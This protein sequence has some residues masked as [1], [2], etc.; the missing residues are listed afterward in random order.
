MNTE[1]ERNKRETQR[2]TQRE[3]QSERM[4]V[5]SPSRSAHRFFKRIQ[6]EN[7][8]NVHT[9]YLNEYRTRTQQTRDAERDAQNI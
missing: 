9:E 8:T 3:T 7:A 6:N 4:C 2:D 5:V 1:R